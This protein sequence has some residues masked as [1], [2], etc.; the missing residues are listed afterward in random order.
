MTENIIV[1]FSVP[2]LKSTVKLISKDELGDCCLKSW[3]GD[4]TNQMQQ[5]GSHGNTVPQR[6][7]DKA[8]QVLHNKQQINEANAIRSHD[9]QVTLATTRRSLTP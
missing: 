5:G 4:K 1:R 6:F 8:R 3:L 9:T 7:A 2:S